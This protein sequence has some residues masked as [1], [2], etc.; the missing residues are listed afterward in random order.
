MTCENRTPYNFCFFQGDDHD[1]D[2]FIQDTEGEVLPLTNYIF[3]MQ[4]RKT[5]DSDE[6]FT[7]VHGDGITV[8]PLEG[9]IQISIN[10]VR[11]AALLPGKYVYDIERTDPAGKRRKSLFGTFDVLAESTKV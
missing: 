6:E 3:K 9:K 11:T 1:F 8:V 2:V 10:N 7:L 4:A 5:Y